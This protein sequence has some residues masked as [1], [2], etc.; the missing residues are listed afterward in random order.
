MGLVEIILGVWTS[1]IE[2]FTDAMTA[3]IPFFYTA[4]VGDAPGELTIYGV[5]VVI[6]LALAVAMLVINRVV[7]FFRLRG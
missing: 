5:L 1:L 3:L 2:W 7:D 6:S 4:P